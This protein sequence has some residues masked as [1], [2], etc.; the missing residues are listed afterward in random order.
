VT[1]RS[2]LS[3]G[4]VDAILATA[5][6]LIVV[7]ASLSSH[8]QGATHS[9]AAAWVFGA[10]LAL[11]ALVRRR[12]PVRVLLASVLVVLGYHAAGF[13]AIG[14]GWPLA[15]ALYTCASTGRLRPAIVVGVVLAVTS[16]VVRLVIQPDPALE[17]LST[18]L[19]EMAVVALVLAFGDAVRSRRGWAA[20]LRARLG[21]LERE[22]ELEAG[23]LVVQERLRVA[24]EL[25]DVM[26]HTL[27][28]ATVQL[29]VAADAID[30]DPELARAAIG[31][32]QQVARQ[33][34][35]ELGT[36]VRVLRSEDEEDLPLAPAPGLDGVQRLLAAARESGLRVEHETS[37][38]VRPLPAPVGLAVHRIVQESLTNVLRHAGAGAVVVRLRYD[39]DG[40]AVHVA[41]DG[42]GPA[43][44]AGHPGGHGLVGMRERAVGLGG[45]FDAGPAPA[46]G[47]AV[48]AWLPAPS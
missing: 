12:W 33:A 36:A 10:L 30:D 24:R 47:F 19:Q 25:H 4:T 48:D 16:S 45:R 44:A 18:T 22:R 3:P 34:T 26:A 15:V 28:V 11:L 23:R 2:R 41:D 43:G 39:Q 27:T 20:E 35:G 17:V 42:A 21:R 1:E 29:N 7:L 31:T 13:P 5:L 38:P 37:G 40:V 46:G 6:G 9:V 32:A 8:E 14:S